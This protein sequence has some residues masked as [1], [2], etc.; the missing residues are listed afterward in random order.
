VV[1]TRFYPIVKPTVI[2]AT[3]IKKPIVQ[4]RATK[5]KVPNKTTNKTAAT[6]MS[7]RQ[8]AATKSAITKKVDRD[9]HSFWEALSMLPRYLKPQGMGTTY[10]GNNTGST[11]DTKA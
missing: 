7:S 6:N 8:A 4:K 2:V 5:K 9:W 10:E 11:P 1:T 3:V